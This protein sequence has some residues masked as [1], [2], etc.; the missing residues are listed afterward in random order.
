[1]PTLKRVLL[2]VLVDPLLHYSVI[3]GIW[4]SNVV[5]DDCTNFLSWRCPFPFLDLSSL[6][7]M[8]KCN[9]HCNSIERWQLSRGD[10]SPVLCHSEYTNQCCYGT[11]F[12]VAEMSLLVKKMADLS[13]SSLFICVDD[14][15]CAVPRDTPC[16]SSHRALTM[17]LPNQFNPYLPVIVL[18]GPPRWWTVAF[19]WAVV[20]FVDLLQAPWSLVKPQGRWGVIVGGVTVPGPHSVHTVLSCCLELFLLL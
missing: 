7:F 6:N 14:R 12:I 5:I 13:P 1:M 17:R 15:H 9:C 4:L 2:M 20:R 18:A 3:L 8:L 10:W 19:F 11:V 16:L